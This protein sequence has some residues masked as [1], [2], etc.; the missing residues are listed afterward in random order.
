MYTLNFNAQELQALVQL[1]DIATKAGGLQVAGAALA[2]SQKVTNAMQP[3]DPE[4][5]VNGL[6]VVE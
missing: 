3:V 2:L 4:P 6:K 1:L 5:V